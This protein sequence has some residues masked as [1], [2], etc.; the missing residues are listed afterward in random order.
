MKHIYHQDIQPL[1]LGCP[2]GAT[3]HTQVTATNSNL[4]WYCGNEGTGPYSTI[5]GPLAP[6]EV[7]ARHPLHIRIHGPCRWVVWGLGRLLRLGVSIRES[8]E[9]D[10]IEGKGG[11]YCEVTGRWRWAAVVIYY[12][13]NT[14]YKHSLFASRVWR[15]LWRQ[16]WKLMLS[17]AVGRARRV[18]LGHDV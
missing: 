18:T 7:I 14:F 1:T 16:H 9:S 10:E 15:L 17:Q 12:W 4:V 2:D 8:S 6:I 11:G 5:P 13:T 3:V